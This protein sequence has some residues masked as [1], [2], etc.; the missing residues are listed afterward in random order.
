MRGIRSFTLADK[1]F[2]KNRHKYQ[3]KIM[4]NKSIKKLYQEIEEIM[5]F[6]MQNIPNGEF[7]KDALKMEKEKLIRSQVISDCTLI[8]ELIGL[9]IMNEILEDS[10]SWR[11]IKYF[12]RIKRFRIFSDEI[13]A[14]ISPF[15]KLD[16]LKKLTFIPHKTEK[17]TRKIFDLRNLFAH[18]FTLDY[19]KAEKILYNGVSIFEISN[20]KKYCE[21]STGVIRFF[22]RR[23]K[24]L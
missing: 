4:P 24:V 23:S 10:K 1:I 3:V 11:T 17:L 20:F 5:A 9:A 8:E 2:L 18:T 22:L 16:I 12:G 15:R 14:L 13:L 21:D 19:S 7:Q 6:K